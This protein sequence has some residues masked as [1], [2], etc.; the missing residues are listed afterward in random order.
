MKKQATMPVTEHLF[1]VA[2]QLTKVEEFGISFQE[3]VSGQVTL[4]PQGARF[5]IYFAGSIEGEKIK[6]SIVG[7]DHAVVRADGRF[8]LNLIETITTDDGEIIAV[9]GD[10]IFGMPDPETGFSQ[11]RVNAQM[12]TFSPKYAWL[13]GLQIWETGTSY[14]PKGEIR[15]KAYVA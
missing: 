2:I 10:G 14:V 12:T 5:D 7:V 13:N 4:P 3:L 9:R 1:D 6:G 8:D 11:I 15:L